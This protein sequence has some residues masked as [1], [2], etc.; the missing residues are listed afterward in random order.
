MNGQLSSCHHEEQSKRHKYTERMADWLIVIW[1]VRA[2][3]IVVL[4]IW[5]LLE[6]Q[7][8]DGWTKDPDELRK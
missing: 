6:R 2:V 5:C 4:V 1:S 3:P 8:E 7:E